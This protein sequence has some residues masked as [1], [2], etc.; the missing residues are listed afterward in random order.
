MIIGSEG[1]SR[2]IPRMHS[3]SAAPGIAHV[4]SE[5]C[6]ILGVKLVAY[7]A[8]ESETCAV[9]EW[10]AGERTPSESIVQRLQV[11]Y[12]VAGLLHEREG[13]ATVQSWFRGLNPQLDDNAPAQ[14]LRDS[15][16]EIATREV[17]A[18]AR[19]FLAVG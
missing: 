12:Y 13:K 4:V 3:D 11:A 2:P 15:S 5:L 9:R 16:L 14:A 8:H 7:I 18:A 19:G 10:A 1:P 17:V 6:G